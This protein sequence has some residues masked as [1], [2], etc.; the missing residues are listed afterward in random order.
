MIKAILSALLVVLLLPTA[1]NAQN[2]TTM[3]GTVVRT[4]SGPRWAGIVV[5]I[6]REEYGVQ[7]RGERGEAAIVGTVD[8]GRQV[9]V[10][11][12]GKLDCSSPRNGVRCWV[13][14]TKIL[15][16]KQIVP[17]R[18]SPGRATAVSRGSLASWDGTKSYSIAAKRGQTITIQLTSRLSP[19]DRR[20]GK[21]S[22][23][24]LLTRDG[25]IL[26][27]GVSDWRGQLASTDTYILVLTLAGDLPYRQQVYYALDVTLR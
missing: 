22:T 11:Y 5:A 1:F 18:F 14:A 8:V 21:Y 15:E 7:T 12:T 20:T 26:V 3:E 25:Q 2:T 23:F 4:V 19:R 16:K 9:E 10:T 24:R 27:E 6:G 17:I 13:S